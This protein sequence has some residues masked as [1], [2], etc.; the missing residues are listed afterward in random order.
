ME[1]VLAGLGRLLAQLIVF[2]LLYLTGRAIVGVVSFGRWQVDESKWRLGL[3]DLGK[4]WKR[5]PDGQIYLGETAAIMIGLLFWVVLLS[6]LVA[7]LN[8]AQ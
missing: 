7:V 3:S 5:G 6:A 1:E 4:V 8:K 2:G